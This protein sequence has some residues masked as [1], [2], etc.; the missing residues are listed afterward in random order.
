VASKVLKII[1]DVG[2]GKPYMLFLKS[3]NFVRSNNGIEGRGESK[4]QMMV[5]NELYRGLKFTSIRKDAD[6]LY[7]V[8]WHERRHDL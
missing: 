8:L 2:L 4:K 7:G 3:R 5:C 6:L 1:Y